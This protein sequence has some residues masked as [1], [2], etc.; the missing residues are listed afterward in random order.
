MKRH[1]SRLMKPY[2]GTKRRRPPTGGAAGFTLVE[3]LL[4][5]AILGIL[6]GVVVVSVRNRV[7][8]TQVAACRMSIKSLGTA[9]DAYEVDNGVLPGSLQNLSTKGGEM[10]WNGPYIQ[11]TPKDP[12]GNPFSY[13]RDGN[14][15]RIVSGGPDGN[16]GSGD[17][18]TN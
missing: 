17:D 6:A 3:V 2:S 9:I 8:Q 10:N 16:V 1:I 15:Y 11:G 14:S 13:S 7:P 18:I 4:V 5:V 12:W